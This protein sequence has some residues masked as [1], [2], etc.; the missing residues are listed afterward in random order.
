MPIV[1]GAL[2]PHSPLLLP[3]LKPEVR[4]QVSKT[5]AAITA[6]G[7][8]LVTLE[9]DVLVVVAAHT[10]TDNPRRGY[11][12]LQAPRLAYAF[13]QLGDLSTAGTFH[14]AVGFIHRLKERLETSF[15]IPLATMGNL[16]YTFALP[17]VTLGSPLNTKPVVCLQLPKI[18]PLDELNTLGA[19]LA[20]ALAIT[21]ERVVLL[22]SGDLAHATAQTATAAKI[23]DQLFQTACQQNS[24]EQ[25]V[26][27]DPAVRKLT[28]ECLHAPAC[29]LYRL[30]Q[31]QAITTTVR[32]YEAPGGVG[33]LVA[34]V[35]WR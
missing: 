18:I 8:A 2:L 15:P 23:F 28:R 5:S 22:G 17:L 7:Q 35:S 32:S 27:L 29:L 6:L 14:G 3:A 25:L 11:A 19:L 20:E 10:E 31:D 30:A 4:T 21:R 33:L 26:N 13:N 9:P 24:L 12:L 34:E 1:G 16:P